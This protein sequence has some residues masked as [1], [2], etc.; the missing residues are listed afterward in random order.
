M[1][2]ALVVAVGLWLSSVSISAFAQNRVRFSGDPLLV[3]AGARSL[4]LGGAYVALSEDATAVYWNAAG[5]ARLE[6]GEVQAQHTEQFGGIVNNDL[7]TFVLPTRAGGL[8]VGITRV[9]VDGVRITRLEDEGRPLGP[10]NRPEVASTAGTSDHVLYLGFGKTIRPR[11]SVGSTIKI[12]WR[13]L[14]VGSGSGF[15][16]DAGLRFDAS[17]DLTAAI[18]IRDLTR[19]SISF[20]TGSRDKISPSLL[21]GLAYRKAVL[22]GTFTSSV[23]V[24]LNEDVASEESSQAQKLGL[25]YA[26]KN[27]LAFRLGL[28]GRQFTAGGGLR[29]ARR[30]GVDLAFLEDADL[31]NT[32]R[33]SASVFF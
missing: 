23:S 11:W 13:N 20:D 9:S 4:A 16:F 19:T 26:H 10:D 14:V 5:L 18:V 32:F 3:G 28:N 24:H 31:D 33:I 29:V 7:L 27:G 22:S 12:V 2:R 25:E 1:K 15:G 17:P 6:R 21:A 8:G 30:F